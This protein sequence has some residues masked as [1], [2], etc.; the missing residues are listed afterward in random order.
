MVAAP[1]S[2]RTLFGQL[3]FQ[4]FAREADTDVS[5]TTVRSISHK[6]DETIV[7]TLPRIPA[8]LDKAELICRLRNDMKRA[9]S[10]ISPK[11]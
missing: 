5:V 9:T 6:P 8:R 4:V 7:R 10:G 2:L 3:M 11:S 1:L